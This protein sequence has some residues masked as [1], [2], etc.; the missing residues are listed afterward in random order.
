MNC[1]DIQIPHT[2]SHFNQHDRS[3]DCHVNS[4]SHKSFEIM[5]AFQNQGPILS[6][7]FCEY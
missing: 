4:M 5:Q 6:K 7:N 3:L 2:K 1:S